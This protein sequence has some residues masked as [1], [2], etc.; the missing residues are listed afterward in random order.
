MVST[1]EPKQYL[2]MEIERD[3]EKQIIRLHQTQYIQKILKR[4]LMHECNPCR[5]PTAANAMQQNNETPLT[6]QEKKLKNVQFREKIGSGLVDSACKKM[7]S[8]EKKGKGKK[9]EKVVA[10]LA[11]VQRV[12]VSSVTERQPVRGPFV[13]SI[14]VFL[15]KINRVLEVR[16]SSVLGTVRSRR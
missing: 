4:F 16:I 11:V 8:R 12:F 2:G 10:V 5:T 13:V 14:Y 9:G 7:G 15:I 3:P 6:E 1:G